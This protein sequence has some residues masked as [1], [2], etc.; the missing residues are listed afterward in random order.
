MKELVRRAFRALGYDL[1]PRVL[2]ADMD[3][4]FAQIAVVCAPFTMTPRE[5]LYGLYQAVCYVT[6]AHVPGD[7]VEC[8]VWRGGSCMAAALTLIDLGSTAR[9]IYLYDT[10]AGMTKPGEFDVDQRST[11]ALATW[12]RS[13]RGDVNRWCYASLDEVRSNLFST[14]YPPERLRFVAGD[15][16]ATLPATAPQTIAILRLDTDFY[17]ST[18]HAL[19]HLFDRLSRGG[20]LIVDDYGHWQG[21]KKAIDEY[22]AA[23]GIAMLLNRL[24]YAARIGV[25]V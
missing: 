3:T 6:A 20:V 5:R 22:F 10:F 12:E 1:V 21:A 14:G 17:E 16:L 13:Q 2:P 18:T 11:R 24:D 19:T 9:D 23:H 15:L 8:G 4:R 7:I 25:K